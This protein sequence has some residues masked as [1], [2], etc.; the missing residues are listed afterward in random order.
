M[1]PLNDP[2]GPGGDLLLRGTTASSGEGDKHLPVGTGEAQRVGQQSDG[3]ALGSADPRPLQ[4]PDGPHPDTRTIGKL[5]LGQA[6]RQSLC[7][8]NSGE[9][10]IPYGQFAVGS[11]AHGARGYCHRDQEKRL[12]R[13]HDSG[14][15]NSR[16]NPVEDR[17]APVRPESGPSLAPPG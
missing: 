1:G 11:H 5:L 12:G 10:R 3:A 14:Y 4:L 16:Q 17:M 6:R 8:K 13:S 2:T 7:A 15:A 9:W